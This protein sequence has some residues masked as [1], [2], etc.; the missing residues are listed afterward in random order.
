MTA[1][2]T[3]LTA[4][5]PTAP[6][7]F[8]RSVGGTF[9]AYLA[10]L[11][12]NLLVSIIVARTMGPSG[13]GVIALALV[14]PNILALLGNLGL[15]AAAS[16]FLRREPARARSIVGW[17]SALGA[18]SGAA[19]M[20]AYVAAAPHIHA[21]LGPATEPGPDAPL[22][23]LTLPTVMLAAAIIPLEIALQTFMAAW[24][25]WQQFGARNAIML[26]YRWL[27]AALAASAIALYRPEPL[28]VL[29]AGVAA[30]V[31]TIFAGYWCLGRQLHDRPDAP[32]RLSDARRL[33]GY[34]WR[35]HVGAVL[36]FLIL[37]VDLLVVNLLVGD[38]AQVGL[39]SRAVQVAEVVLY[40]MLAVENVLFPA[41]SG[42]SPSTAQGGRDDRLRPCD[43]RQAA[44]PAEHASAIYR[45][46][47]GGLVAG[48]ALMVVFEIGAEWLIVLPFGRAFAG[49]VEPLRIL[50]PAALAIGLARA[51]FSVFNALERPLVA[52][53]IAAAGLVLITALDLWW[54]P[55]HGIRG[56]AWASL[57]TYVAM[58][59]AALATLTRLTRRCSVCAIVVP[60][61]A[62]EDAAA[63]CGGGAQ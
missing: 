50:L 13:A 34:A 4:E 27:Y 19:L 25:G 7:P 23:Q 18:L 14:G 59:A 24:Q 5:P 53:A 45:M 39:Y 21:A 37:R 15:P 16:H 61:E 8:A 9:L 2:E 11:A 62:S 41:V 29:A 51:L 12:A 10:A 22:F 40:F 17:T 20:I 33:L 54:I 57:V 1:D 36:V 58:A 35:T 49:S 63:G 60:P 43:S 30:Y 44:I 52:A 47:R 56:A 31:V 32:H 26:T 42:L 3:P 38:V 48:L 6:P 46:L 28:A 55:E